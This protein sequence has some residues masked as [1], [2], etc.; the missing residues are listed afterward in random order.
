MTIT[1]PTGYA[2][3]EVTLYDASDD[4]VR[5]FVELSWLM[6]RE[7][8]PEDPPRPFEAAA[9]RMTMRTSL[10][11]QRRWAAW[12]PQRGLA[13][14]VVMWRPLQDNLHIRDIYVAVRP[15]HR[16]R[17]LGHALFVKALDA[18]EGGEGLLAQ[19]WTHSRVPP[20]E[21]F[22]RHVGAKPGLRM[23]ASQLDLASIDRAL[24]K[25][26]AALDP[27]GYRLEWVLAEV[28]DRL[29]D[30]VV[31]AIRAINTM[32]KEDLV[33][34]DW[35]ITPET[36]RE[37]ERLSRERGQ[38]RWMALAVDEATG[39]SAGF[40]DIFFDPRVPSVLHQGG[41]AVIPAHRGKGLG[42]WVK[43]RMAERIL[44]DMPEARYIRTENAGTN[45]AM[46]AI[47]VGMGFKPAWEEVIWQVPVPET[48]RI[49]GAA[50]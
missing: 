31:A 9:R 44:R 11:E 33:W 24:M 6:E 19:L 50:R 36:V 42:K 17:G 14:A 20:A 40:T 1:A 27:A 34:E 16:R 23:R 30:N 21:A 13:G 4:V 12:T 43:A 37:W 32:P 8:V 22:A 3:E 18:I 10:G 26:W 29:M 25:E 5:P 47:N 39:E 2:I 28:P 15:E 46:L 38:R 48:R 49:V 41:T 35:K 45:A 7:A